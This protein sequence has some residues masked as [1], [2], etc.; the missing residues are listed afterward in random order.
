MI[1]LYIDIDGVLLTKR[2]TEPAD[3]AAKFI[4]F[5]TTHFDC[6]WLTTHCKGQSITAINYLKRYFEGETLE[7]LKTIKPTNWETLKTEA[8]D[9]TS[10]F[11]WLDDYPLNIEEEWMKKHDFHDKLIKVN[12]MNPNELVNVIKQLPT[13]PK[14]H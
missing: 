3:G 8:L 10:D 9:F 13:K 11:F 4:E 7:L 6:Y 5:I 1:K 12:L 2:L 14:L